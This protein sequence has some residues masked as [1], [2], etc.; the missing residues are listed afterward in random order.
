[1]A[2]QAKMDSCHTASLSTTARAL[3]IRVA[4]YQ[5]VPGTSVRP[6]RCGRYELGVVHL[7]CWSSA[8]AQAQVG[9]R[10]DLKGDRPFP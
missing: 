7:P 9:S 2:S 6:L 3:T 8:A 10:R 4:R 5:P 1:M